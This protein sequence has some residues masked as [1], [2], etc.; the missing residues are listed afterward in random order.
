MHQQVFHNTVGEWECLRCDLVFRDRYE[1]QQHNKTV[2]SRVARFNC[3]H[4]K[5][6]AYSPGMLFNSIRF[7]CAILGNS[8]AILSVSFFKSACNSFHANAIY[9]YC[10]NYLTFGHIFNPIELPPGG[11][12]TH[13]KIV[14]EKIKDFK[15]GEC[16]F[17]TSSKVTLKNHVKR[18][19]TMRGVEVLL[20]KEEVVWSGD[21]CEISEDHRGVEPITE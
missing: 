19:H 16:S 1:E 9:T 5:F 14:H 20:P 3:G 7:I 15:C 8:W 17:E 21:D 12:K 2:H 10:L 13:I 4:C 18:E 6:A 11:L